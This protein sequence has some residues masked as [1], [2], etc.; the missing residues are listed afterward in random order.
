MNFRPICGRVYKL[1]AIRNTFRNR[2]ISLSL[3]LSP[4]RLTHNETASCFWRFRSCAVC[5]Q[6]RKL[7][8][9][10]GDTN[11]WHP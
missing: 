6:S 9:R 4:S 1:Y 10:C 7:R 3:S 5:Q 2:E 8:P 11:N